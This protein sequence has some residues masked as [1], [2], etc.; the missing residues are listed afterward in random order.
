ML[1]QSIIWLPLPYYQ[2]AESLPAI[3]YQQALGLLFNGQFY[4]SKTDTI[5]QD[6]VISHTELVYYPPEY[7]MTIPGYEGYS[8]PFYKFYIE[9]P[10]QQRETL[11]GILKEYYVCYVCALDPACVDLTGDYGVENI[12]QFNGAPVN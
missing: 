9:D 12:V 6:A 11:G 8:L 7:K 3:T 10:E 4:S 5:P 2:K 1:D